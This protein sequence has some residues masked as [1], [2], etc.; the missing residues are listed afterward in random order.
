[1]CSDRSR[2]PLSSIIDDKPMM[3]LPHI[4]HFISFSPCWLNLV[5][6]C[7]AAIISASQTPFTFCLSFRLSISIFHFC[8]FVFTLLRRV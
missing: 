5:L 6:C 4:S 8:Q 1:V 2:H 3:N 7:D